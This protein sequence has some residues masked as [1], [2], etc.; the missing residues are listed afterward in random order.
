MKFPPETDSSWVRDFRT[1]KGTSGGPDQFGKAI[2]L[3]EM[4]IFDPRQVFIIM[5]GIYRGSVLPE[6]P[7]LEFTTLQ[8]LTQISV[9]YNQ[10][11]GDI[12]IDNYSAVLAYK[13]IQSEEKRRELFQF[14]T[15]YF[16][17]KKESVYSLTIQMPTKVA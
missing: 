5:L 11:Q 13:G 14:L 3:Q 9:V 15:K 7:Q 10:Q 12:I 2:P 1:D 8:I 16:L 17:E 4:Q 6:L